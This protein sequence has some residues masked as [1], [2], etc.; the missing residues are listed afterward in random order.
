M[1]R[2][3][4]KNGIKVETWD[5]KAFFF[6]TELQSEVENAMVLMGYDSHGYWLSFFKDKK[7]PETP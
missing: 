6:Y 3:S 4:M 7:A 1:G 2:R 5:N